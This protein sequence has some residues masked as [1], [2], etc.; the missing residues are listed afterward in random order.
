[1]LL[2]VPATFHSYIVVV[3]QL[4]Y[5]A[6]SPSFTWRRLTH[7][8][9]LLGPVEHLAFVKTCF[10][11]ALPQYSSLKNLRF[12]V[13]LRRLQRGA[14][15]QSFHLVLTSTSAMPMERWREWL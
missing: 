8:K 3:P 5:T 12:K 1:M 2:R 9:V 6:L 10:V 15:K 11:D 13:G 14:P 7:C 4:T